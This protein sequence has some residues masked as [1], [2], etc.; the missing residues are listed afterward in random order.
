MEFRIVDDALCVLE[1]HEVRHHYSGGVRLERSD[2]IAVASVRNAGKRITVV[3]FCSAYCVFDKRKV[4][5]HVLHIEP[6]AVESAH[7]G[8]LR[9]ARIR[10]VK[11]YASCD[12]AASHL[13]ENTAFSHIHR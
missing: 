8:D 13:S 3:N 5:R 1:A 7:C 10:K 11:L 9:G 2:K 12:L 4:A 6:D